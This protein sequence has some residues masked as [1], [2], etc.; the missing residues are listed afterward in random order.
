MTI[1]P[2]I[3]P[4]VEMP[5][6][7]RAAWCVPLT[8]A[9]LLVWPVPVAHP[10]H[11]PILVI[12]RANSPNL[13][14]FWL[15]AGRLAPGILCFFVWQIG[16]SVVNLW[17]AHLLEERTRGQLP[18]WPLSEDDDGPGLVI[19]EKHY[20]VDL[21]EHHHPTWCVMP[22]KG[23][24]TGLAIFG[25]IGTG[26]TSSCMYPFVR[27]LLT[28]QHNDSEKR[29]AGLVLEVKGDFCYDVQEMLKEYGR[30]D[31]YMEIGTGEDSKRWN[32]MNCPWLDTYSLAYSLASIVNQL[33]GAGK[34][35][36]WQQA[37]TN[38]IRWIIQAYRVFPDP[39]FTFHDIYN[40]MIEKEALLTLV[41]DATEHVYGKYRY[42]VQMSRADFNQYRDDLLEL[43]MYPAGVDP[44]DPGDAKPESFKILPPEQDPEDIRICAWSDLSDRVGCIMGD[45]P[46]KA[47]KRV[48]KKHELRYSCDE[49]EAPTQAEIDL[50]KKISQWYASEWLGLDEKL[51]S[52]I[53]EGMSVF[54]GVFVVPDIAR[55]FCPPRPA[56]Q[57]PED[58]KTMLPPLADCIESGKVLAL[59][60]P[61]GANPALARAVG[62]MLKGSWLG[63]LLLR[64]KA[65]KLDKK[66]VAE[67][68]AAG[69]DPKPKYFRP[70]MFICDE[71]QSFATCGEKDPAGD[72]KA[73]ALTRQSKCIPIVAT[74][75]IVS[76]KSVI[77]DGDAWR[78][79]L[80]TLRSRI[81]LSLA[82]DFSLETASKL[83]GQVNRMRASYSLSENTAQAG[84]SLFTGRVGG[85]KASAGL[86]KS[87]QER[88][89]ALFQPR[90]LN[91]LGTSQAVAQI[92][93]GRIMRDAHRVFLKP[94]Y[95][96]RDMPYWRQR[97]AGLL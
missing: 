45:R 19:G 39:W 59:N 3:Q 66:R 52:S 31:D 78:A 61:A 68:K 27:Q 67:E 69:K 48:M 55:I 49:I 17:L 65:M 50:D 32:P 4:L 10:E 24:Y 36:F 81:F 46:F 83:L 63:A 97:D 58:L 38:V 9:I 30:L 71:Y 89:D 47:L 91:L 82:D 14:V 51:R 25:A 76:L 35:P 28:W 53:V 84:A 74:Q 21:K 8:L 37:Y 43:E 1:V 34:D 5:P 92:F 56:D 87:F 64:P 94:Y 6:W 72:E 75:S 80:Q 2:V 44:E 33:F 96:D 60:M 13:Y 54:L 85:G 79:L 73:F 18:P 90:D 16:A 20:P 23:L 12:L 15:W 41:N 22:E 95:L 62:V 70:A 11:H 88:R 42:L 77:G 93:D 7:Q 57:D 86:S 26:K 29:V 40:C